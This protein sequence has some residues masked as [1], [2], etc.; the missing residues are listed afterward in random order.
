MLAKALFL[1][2]DGV[3]NKAPRTGEYVTSIDSL[4]LNDGIIDFVSFMRKLGFMIIVITNQRCVF[5]ELITP[6]EL[7]N[8]H[9]YLSEIFK[10]ES[11]TIDKIYC[12]THDNNSCECRKPK[13]GMIINAVKELD[14]D[15]T[16]SI[17]IGDTWRDIDLANMLGI[18]SYCVG[19]DCPR[20]STVF[21]NIKDL[22]GFF[23]NE[24][25]KWKR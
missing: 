7:D 20:E 25:F 4:I 18:E 15:L 13:P 6:E 3:I 8:I 11:A 12:C 16:S 2:R 22:H 9:I 21:E 19:R 10:K 24:R 14:I 23:I 17:L 1:D 5:L